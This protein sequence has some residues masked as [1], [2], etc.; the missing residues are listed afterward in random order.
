[1]FNLLVIDD[2]RSFLS[3]VERWLKDKYKVFTVNNINSGIA[4]LKK[5]NIS[6]L[7]LDLLLPGLNGFDLLKKIHKEIDPN[8]PIIILSDDGDVEAV[9]KA[10]NL[11][12]ADYIQKDLGS[13]LLHQKIISSIDKRSLGLELE[14]LKDS[15]DR[16][17]D[18]FI[19]KSKAMQKVNFDIAKIAGSNAD[20]LLLGETGT[21]KDVIAYQLH[22]RSKRKDKLFVE[23]SLNSLSDTLIESEL[24]GYEKG[25]FSGADSAK[26]GKFEAADGGTVYLPEISDISEKIQA[27]LLSFMQYK[28]ISK[29]GSGNAKKIKLDVRLI[30][31]SNKDL[32]QLVK[33]GKL[34]EDFYYRINVTKINVPPLRMRRDGIEN[35]CDYFL[36]IS[37]RKHN[38][39]GITFSPGLLAEIKKY[40]WHGNIRELKN[41]IES[42]VV[43]ADNDA[44]LTTND[45]P[46]LIMP[47]VQESGDDGTLESA[48]TKA[49]I[50]YINN[51]L[52]ETNHNKT[53][54]AAKAGLSRQG[55]LNI[56]KELG[57]Q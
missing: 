38:K 52:M 20:V 14:T 19:C 7:L 2:D 33:E 47:I 30:M 18:Y 8:L 27:K 24:F 25:A 22:K 41:T 13:S 31:A 26:I 42:A 56:L 34:R 29:V 3:D 39:I 40:D 54:A 37:L 1:M 35:L 17:Y 43:M 9:V 32:W 51:L 44:A 15:Q 5:E 55:L 16:R 46:N 21:G 53:R 45:F 4:I 11:G 12:A 6:I 10:M 49:K 48:M 50:D 36:S 57:I 23:V 28:E